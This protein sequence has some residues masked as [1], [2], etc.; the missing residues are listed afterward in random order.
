MAWQSAGQSSTYRPGDG[1]RAAWSMQSVHP[2]D[3]LSLPESPGS[4]N[5]SGRVMRGMR[6][7]APIVNTAGLTGGRSECLRKFG[8]DSR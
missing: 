5:S 2:R 6:W 3:I 4:D 8:A 7:R 1:D